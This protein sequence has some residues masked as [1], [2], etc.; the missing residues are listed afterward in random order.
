MITQRV[1]QTMQ[2]DTQGCP[3]SETPF[4]FWLVSTPGGVAP[5]PSTIFPTWVEDFREVKTGD[6]RRFH[7]CGDG[8][9]TKGLQAGAHK[10]KR[11]QPATEADVKAAAVATAATDALKATDPAATEQARKSVTAINEGRAGIQL[12]DAS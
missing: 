2:C 5:D 10:R 9:E 7:Y 1:M 4:Q 3:H 11:I 8:C 6:G 12:T